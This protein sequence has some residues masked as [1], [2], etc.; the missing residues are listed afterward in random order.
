[1]KVAIEYYQDG[2]GKLRTLTCEGNAATIDTA[3]QK[4]PEKER[5]L[6]PRRPP[7]HSRP[8]HPDPPGPPKQHSTRR[9]AAVSLRF[10]FCGARRS[11]RAKGEL[12]QPL[13]TPC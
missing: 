4:L 2:T 10:A 11:T 12:S 13:F 1:M 5:G 6:R 3:V 7:A 8:G 9:E